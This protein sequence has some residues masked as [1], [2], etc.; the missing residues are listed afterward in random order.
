MNKNKLQSG[1][2]KI[3]KRSSTLDK[4]Q[5]PTIQQLA[6][7]QTYLDTSQGLAMRVN[8]P[9]ANLVTFIMGF[10]LGHRLIIPLLASSQLLACELLYSEC[11]GVRSSEFLWE[12]GQ[13]PNCLK[14]IGY[15]LA[16]LVAG[17]ANLVTTLVD[18]AATNDERI[19]MSLQ[20]YRQHE[21]IFLDNTKLA[22]ASEVRK[23]SL[24]PE[25][26]E[27][28]LGKLY[29]K[30]ISYQ[31]PVEITTRYL[32][33]SN[34]L[35]I[36]IEYYF[37]LYISLVSASKYIVSPLLHKLFPYGVVSPLK[38]PYSLRKKQLSLSK[39]EIS[40]IINA[41]RVIQQTLEINRSKLTVLSRLIVLVG[42]LIVYSQD[43]SPPPYGI[44]TFL[45]KLLSCNQLRDLALLSFISTAL[46][47][48]FDSF[49]QPYLER[50]QEKTVKRV[51]K[52]LNVLSRGI[53]LPDWNRIDSDA[54][55]ACYF[56]LAIFRRA[57]SKGGERF[58]GIP[59][60]RLIKE[61]VCVLYQYKP[62]NVIAYNKHEITLLL[63]E[64]LSGSRI[65]EITAA[66]ESRLASIKNKHKLILQLDE[67]LTSIDVKPVYE[68]QE[69]N[70]KDCVTDYTFIIQFAEIP[71]FLK[72]TLYR[73]LEVCFGSHCVSRANENSV[74]LTHAMPIEQSSH[75]RALKLLKACVGM[76]QPGLIQSKKQN[77][78]AHEVAEPESCFNKVLGA[79]L[80]KNKRV[81]NLAPQVT[82]ARL[83]P[84]EKYTWPSGTY[85]PSGEAKVVKIRG[86]HNLFSLFKLKRKD[87]PYCQAE[88]Y[89]HFKA[90]ITT[91]ARIVPK[92][93]NQGIVST[94]TPVKDT[95]GEWFI[96]NYKAKALGRAHGNIRVYAR[97][98]NDNQGHTLLVFN[99]VK[100]RSH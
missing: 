22:L 65:N 43:D 76:D 40:E 30:W 80:K 7:L 79:P 14:A 90:I 58:Q 53:K 28:R 94:Q 92:R 8:R 25:M 51:G 47:G 10:R 75:E 29:Q 66:F 56:H 83:S 93:D 48:L 12:L 1:S 50:Q 17:F 71:N 16:D 84:L 6:E 57:I 49:Y 63:D 27:D 77:T 36:D 39:H 11:L 72:E 24:S 85:S 81:T 33:E 59:I 73:Q 32:H 54:T 89:D 86:A 42:F 5:P 55:G 100:L 4:P 19:K 20:V 78:T 88:A 87:F 67:L 74:T 68:I 46:D 35:I 95:E 62:I 82:P 15:S 61:L 96:A 64:P 9:L 3:S 98:E 23:G 31:S 44:Y 69:I 21:K 70:T 13:L 34:L 37:L 41:Q 52:S 18:S 99:T 38:L 2:V 91:N 97:Q 45:G 26:A 60:S